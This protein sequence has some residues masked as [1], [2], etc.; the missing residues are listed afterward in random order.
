VPRAKVNRTASQYNASRRRV[1]MLWIESVCSL[2]HQ[3]ANVTARATVK[4]TVVVTREMPRLSV[5]SSVMSVPTT[6]MRT[7]AS[8]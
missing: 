5:R 6:L 2:A 4:T 7:T 3:A 1:V 8:Q